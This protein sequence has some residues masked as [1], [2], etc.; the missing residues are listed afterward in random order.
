MAIKIR[1]DSANNP[2]KPT[3]VLS[4]RNGTKLGEL[5]SEDVVVGDNL[6]DVSEISFKIR[7]FIDNKKVE[8]WD[9]VVDFKLLWC[10]EW[11]MWFEI[12][13]DIDESNETI[14]NVSAKKLGVAELSQILLYGI[15]IN[16]ET[17]IAREDYE[18]PT[19]LFNESNHKAS[20][21]HRI[22]EKAPHYSVVHVDYT[23]ANIQRTFSFDGISICDAF[24]EIEEEIGCLFVFDSN[25]DKYGNIQRTISVYDLESNC[26]ACNH[27]SEFTTVCPECGSKN[28]TEGY[29]VDTTIFVTSDE[30]GENIQFATDTGSVKNCFKLEAGDDLLTATIRN[31]N[32]NGTDYIWYISDAVK[33]DMSDE[34]VTKLK[35]YDELYAYYNNDYIAEPNSDALSK[36]NNLITKYKVYN[37]DLETVLSSIKGYSSLM[38]TYYNTINLEL[39]LKSELMPDVDISLTDT[40]A[41]KQVALLTSANLSPISVADVSKVSSASADSAVL[42]MAKTIVD[43]R[44]KVKV[45]TSNLDNTTWTGKFIVT[46]YSDE[47]DVAISDTITI[48]L[49]DDY[50]NFTKQKIEKIL[51]KNNDDGNNTNISG[52]FSMKINVNEETGEIDKNCEF[53]S[54]LKEY[55]LSRLKSFHD[56]CQSCIDILIEQG[57]SDDD[58][59]A[60]SD[61][62]LYKE[63]YLPYYYKLLAIESELKLREEEIFIVSGVYDSDGTLKTYGL[64]NHINDIKNNIQKE[65]NFEDYLG[66]TLWFEFCSYRREDK[67]SNENYV[68]DGLNNTELFN[69]ALEFIEVAN[70]EIYKS[71]ELQ[72]SISTTLKN[73]LV[74]KKFKTLV[75]YFEIGNWIRVKVDDEV[76]RLRLIGYEID[77]NDLSTIS[78]EFSDVMKTANGEID[79]RS[80]IE[81]ATSMA[82]S[83]SS[84]QKQ[85]KQGKSGND[86]LNNWVNNGLALTKMKIVDSADNQNVTWDSHGIL[87]KEYLPI[88][89]SYDDR[90]LKIINRGLYLTD[91]NWKTS[92]AGIG[93]F[94][95]YDPISREMREGYGVIADTIIGNLI[96]S[97]K[98]GIYNTEGNIVLDKSGA[99][100][101]A[102]CTSGENLMNFTIQKKTLN[103]NNEEVLNQM[104]YVDSNGDLI[105]NGSVKI[106]SNNSNISDINDI[107]DD[108][109]MIQIS[110]TTVKNNLD[111]VYTTIDDRYNAVKEEAEKNLSDYKADVGQYMTHDENGLTLGATSST[112]KT[113]I[114]NKRLAFKEGDD[115]VAYISNSQL[116]IENAIVKNTLTLG[117]FFFSPR[118][119]G[120]V[121]LVWQDEEI[122][123]VSDISEIDE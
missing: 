45:D 17:D 73:L 77:Y 51:N 102:D 87:C 34:L 110:D 104:F 16:T 91:D 5:K 56:S 2:E 13:V 88:T 72:H 99:T 119:D 122:E 97:E 52:L 109:R 54:A 31:C 96:L 10:K 28:I 48:T 59:W 106:I 94:A 121:S 78:V 33:E 84:V 29:G 116:Y 1:F 63:L 41:T 47:E 69:K 79:Q 60:D 89:D 105:L 37:E 65:L 107:C 26:L 103:E 76:Y 40:D 14:K 80:I 3:L 20:L 85:A 67:Y 58:S 43:L 120:G 7:K 19:I 90:Q 115:T 24:N 74:I 108:N 82:S 9:K 70:K 117:N 12:A 92:K 21:L 4:T 114:D 64:Q 112:F 36:Y 8:L 118:K 123:I 23:I 71:A 81:Q 111:E 62:D 68:S 95:Y 30:L 11:D 39:Y 32:P 101:T 100:I 86:Q 113:V 66:E 15:E 27:R 18:E 57:I 44:Y 25:S 61:P 49:N 98:V 75:E 50:E 22:M 55:C 6:N 42:A 83:Y 93:N 53:C 38:N 46:N 35:E